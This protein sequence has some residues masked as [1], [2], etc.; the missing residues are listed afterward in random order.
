MKK[1]S[2]KAFKLILEKVTAAK[3]RA[4]YGAI[5]VGGGGKTFA[6]EV[7]RENNGTGKGSGEEK[8]MLLIS[9]SSSSVF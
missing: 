3:R 1:S 8:R 4:M 6:L 5:I 2:Q 9:K 7:P